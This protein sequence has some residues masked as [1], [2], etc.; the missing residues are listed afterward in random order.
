MLWWIK[1]AHVCIYT[2]V[3][4]CVCARV[5]ARTYIH[6][7]KQIHGL[8]NK[9]QVYL[10]IGF[11]GSWMREHAW[12]W[13]FSFLGKFFSVFLKA[14]KRTGEGVVNSPIYLHFFKKD[15]AF[16]GLISQQPRPINLHW[17]AVQ[18]QDVWGNCT[19]AWN[20]AFA[21]ILT[22]TEGAA[23]AL[24]TSLSVFYWEFSF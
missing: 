24:T 13:R 8:E 1:N 9:R 17:L 20:Q 18:Q 11:L 6:I 21:S 12:K 19:W 23:G 7:T 3:C 16:R 15:K 10:Q 4:A 14:E 22:L 5:S 2:Y